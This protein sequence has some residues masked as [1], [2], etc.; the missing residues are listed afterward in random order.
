[1]ATSSPRHIV[2]LLGWYYPDSVGGTER[3][4]QLLARDLRALG[5]RVTIAAP[6]SDDQ[7]Q[8]YEYD[9]VPVYRYPIDNTPTTSE[10]QGKTPPRYFT[11]FTR[12]LE[13]QRPDLVHMHS[14]TRGC[15][16][17]HA[18][19]VKSIGL[20]LCVTVHVPSVTCARGT[21]QRW[22]RIPCDGEMRRVRCTV[23]V[24][25]G[26]GV[27][28]AL[29]YLV[30]RL[31]AW[32]IRWMK[33]PPSRF[34][35]GLQMAAVQEHRAARVRQLLS[36]ADRVIAVAQWLYEVLERNGVPGQ[37]LL[38]NRHG[39][40]EDACGVHRTRAVRPATPVL[41]VGYIGR[42]HPTKGVHVL[43]A[44]VRRLPAATPI[45]LYLYGATSGAEEQRYLATVRQQAK[46]DTRIAFMGEMTEQNQ[47]EV[48]GSFD[49][50]AVPS[51][52]LETGPLVVLEA[53]GAGIPVIGSDSGGIAELVT[54]GES[55]LLVRTG[56]IE[57]WTR[58]LQEVA[59]RWRH[60]QWTWRIPSVRASR[61]V[62]LDMQRMYE[63]VWT[64][65]VG[66]R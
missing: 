5:Y 39:L 16:F 62:A 58:T 50:L 11:T 21:M 51:T 13:A 30:A 24:L 25:H 7:E 64:R 40:P 23:C 48:L 44:A 33:L 34:A 56:S 61:A 4:V 54:H 1:M 20:P 32:A 26:R 53:Y 10:V 55:G 9:G 37:K 35:T 43:V 66:A 17:F 8:H 12:W 29:G 19:Y 22:G 45:R 52:W 47:P 18:Q 14:F 65:S 57:A 36:L 28:R 41:R 42:F 15:G 38:L 59:D 6:S 27:P 49:M 63:E 3:Y 31:P 2:F 46:D 60:G